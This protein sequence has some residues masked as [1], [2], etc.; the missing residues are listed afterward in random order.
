MVQLEG[1]DEVKRVENKCKLSKHVFTHT[2]QHILKVTGP[3]VAKI[4]ADEDRRR[5]STGTD[6]IS[7][8]VTDTQAH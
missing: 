4:A 6:A 7:N 3:G 2:L 5:G 8:A 1:T